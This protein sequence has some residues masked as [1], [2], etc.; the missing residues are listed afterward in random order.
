MLTYSPDGH[1][2][3]TVDFDR[4]DCCNL[5]RGEGNWYYRYTIKDG[6]DTI[7][8][9]SDLRS[10]TVPRERPAGLGE[11]LGTLLTFLGAYLD[12]SE[13]AENADLFPAAVRDRLAPAVDG[14]QCATWADEIRPQN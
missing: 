6:D 3:I 7:A 1:L 14:D 5:L 10:G 11:M 2:T 9:G 4:F 12:A 13:G 8:E